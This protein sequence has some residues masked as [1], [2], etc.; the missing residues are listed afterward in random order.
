MNERSL[1]V[2]S[3]YELDVNRTARGRGAYLLWTDKGFFQFIEYNGTEGRLQFEAE[4]LDYIKEAGFER[5]DNIYKT[6]EEKLYSEDEYGTK[7]IIMAFV[8]LLSIVVASVTVAFMKENKD[9]I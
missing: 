7:Y 1:E 8:I 9:E 4:L 6:S 5:V 3:Q 2:L